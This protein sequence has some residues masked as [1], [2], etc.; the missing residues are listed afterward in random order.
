MSLWDVIGGV[1]YALDTPGALLRGLLAGRPGKRV[2]GRELLGLSENKPGLD[3]GDI[4]GFAAEMVVDPLNLLGGAAIGKLAK[5]LS[6]A[7]K[8]RKAGKVAK[9]A[10]AAK[11]SAATK[12]AA[13]MAATGSAIR[14]AD[15]VSPTFRT[16]VGRNLYDDLPDALRDVPHKGLERDLNAGGQWTARHYLKKADPVTGQVT[17]PNSKIPLWVSADS[18]RATAHG[19]ASGKS[20]WHDM[21]PVKKGNY[22][23]AV[24]GPSAKFVEYV[25]ENLKKLPGRSSVM[26][27]GAHEGAHT[28]VRFEENMHDTLKAFLHDATYSARQ[29]ELQGVM[30]GAFNLSGKEMKRLSYLRRPGEMFARVAMLRRAMEKTG[31]GLDEITNLSNYLPDSPLYKTLK[32]YG[33]TRAFNELRTA[34]GNS[35]VVRDLLEK[36]PVIAAAAAVPAAYGAMK[37]QTV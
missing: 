5:T 29:K 7:S 17:N 27:T 21:V 6:S 1:G 19:M 9:A 34:T 30:R 11:A 16:M 32:K 15:S 4:A 25:P 35:S 8:A 31:L 23:A 20:A 12:P 3:S 28:L 22:F 37:Q 13:A 36:V 2:S 33:A 14:A 24:T 10:T 26:A 18:G